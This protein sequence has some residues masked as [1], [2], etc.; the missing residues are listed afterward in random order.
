[1]K[2]DLDRFCYDMFVSYLEKETIDNAE[3]SKKKEPII[4][5]FSKCISNREILFNMSTYYNADEL[6]NINNKLALTTCDT[7][8]K[9]LIVLNHVGS[10]NFGLLFHHLYKIITNSPYIG[11]RDRVQSNY[12]KYSLLFYILMQRNEWTELKIAERLTSVKT[13]KNEKQA[14]EMACMSIDDTT[15]KAHSTINNYSMFG[16]NYNQTTPG[17]NNRVNATGRIVE[18]SDT[19]GS[20]NT[21]TYICAV[22]I[23]AVV[24]FPVAMTIEHNLSLVGRIYSYFKK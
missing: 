9:M 14:K 17:D 18:N 13:A 6:I 5:M 24:T 1:M 11:L 21:T 7:F 4:D 2:T 8:E 22:V 19:V 23:S 12:S 16:S 15:P 10:N 20:N 3:F